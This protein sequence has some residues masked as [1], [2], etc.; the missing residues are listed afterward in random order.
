M[1]KNKFPLLKRRR[2]KKES[3]AFPTFPMSASL[4]R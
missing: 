4:L 2:R 1:S 3:F